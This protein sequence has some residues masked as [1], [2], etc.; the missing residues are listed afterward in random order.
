MRLPPADRTT[1][2]FTVVAASIVLVTISDVAEGRWWNLLL[3]P[4]A[5][6]GC[7]LAYRSWR[8]RHARNLG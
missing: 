1:V 8:R 4:V 6:Y 5:L 2:I 3:L 7:L